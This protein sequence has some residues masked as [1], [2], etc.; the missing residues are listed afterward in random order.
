MA[1]FV[2]TL[3][4]GVLGIVLMLGTLILFR[5][6]RGGRLPLAIATLCLAL[7]AWGV[8]DM[9]RAEDGCEVGA[10]GCGHAEMHPQYQGWQNK[11]GGNCC[12]GEDCR[13]VRAMKDEDGYWRI[14]IPEFKG[15]SLGDW[16]RDGWVIVPQ[17]QVDAQDRFHDGRS[18]ACTSP[19]A[20]LAMPLIYCFSPAQPKI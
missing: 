8:C 16:I 12:S 10:F 2:L 15:K 13:P 18:H 14:F 5:S 19:I 17:S 4:F 7:A 20:G 9:A 6:W 1:T 11:N 3:A